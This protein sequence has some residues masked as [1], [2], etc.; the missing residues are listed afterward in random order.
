VAGIPQVDFRYHS[1]AEMAEA[2]SA[3]T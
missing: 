2:V 3:A 1:L